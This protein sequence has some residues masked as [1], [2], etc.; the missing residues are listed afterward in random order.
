VSGLPNKVMLFKVLLPG[1]FKQAAANK[2]PLG[3]IFISPEGMIEINGKLGRSKGDLLIKKFSECLKKSIQRGERLCHLEGTSFALIVP[4]K[5]QRQLRKRA[6]ALHKDLT[7]RRF[8]LQGDTVSMKVNIG[9]SGLDNLKGITPK[10]LQRALYYQGIS[11]LDTAKHNGN[12][13]EVHVNK[14]P[15]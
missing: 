6:E 12:P 13:I 14:V 11:A 2:Q 15:S 7:C 4:G 1:A 8:D 9:I 10:D 5:P 3:C